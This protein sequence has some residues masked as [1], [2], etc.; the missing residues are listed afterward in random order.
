MDLKAMQKA[1]EKFTLKEPMTLEELYD[2]MKQRWNAELPGT[3]QLKKG[4]MGKSI[5]FDVYM[6]VQPKVTIKDNVVT[7]RKISNSTS[8]SVGGGPGV[9]IKASAEYKKAFKEGGFKDAIS[10]GPAY[11]NGV[12]DAMREI[13]SDLI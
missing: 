9:D 12:C 7:V 11:F 1:V 6:Q 2:L 10:G 8:V 5:L 4:L 13:L 3:F